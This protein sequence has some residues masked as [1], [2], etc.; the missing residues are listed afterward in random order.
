MTNNKH[1]DTMHNN[2][3][4]NRSNNNKPSVNNNTSTDNDTITRMHPSMKRPRAPIACYRCHHK[5]V[6]QINKSIILSLCIYLKS[7]LGSL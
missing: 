2:N 5:K 4:H 6:K 3:S 7:S 1:I